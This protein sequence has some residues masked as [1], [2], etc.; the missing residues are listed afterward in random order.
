ML[1]AF[2]ATMTRYF[3]D[4]RRNDELVTDVEGTDLPDI[5]AAQQEAILS[6]AEMARDRILDHDSVRRLA[7]EVR[8][9]EKSVLAARLVW[10]IELHNN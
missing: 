1:P 2:D 3:F 7:I 5:G 8:D 6:L 10:E 9:Q 4:V